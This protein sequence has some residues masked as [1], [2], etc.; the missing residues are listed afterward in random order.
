MVLDELLEYCREHSRIEKVG[1]DNER[2]LDLMKYVSSHL[3]RFGFKGDA[4]AIEEVFIYDPS[5]GKLILPV[6]L[7]V[8][9]EENCS[10][11][12]LTCG[13]HNKDHYDKLFKLT[14]A[15]YIINRDFGINVEALFVYLSQPN[16]IRT[17]D[18]GIYVPDSGN[19]TF[20]NP[21]TSVLKIE[22]NKT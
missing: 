1:D 18:Y 19:Y 20:N 10:L 15:G 7:V 3:D 13:S 4:I 21:I 5:D 2:H 9:S 6:D 17:Y 8:F 22:P 11:V 12:E 14:R 16:M